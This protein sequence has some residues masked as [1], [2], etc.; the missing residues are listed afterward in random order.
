MPPELRLGLA[1]DQSLRN[2]CLAA[3]WKEDLKS[4]GE[5]GNDAHTCRNL[6]RFFGVLRFIRRQELLGFASGLEWCHQGLELQ[7]KKRRGRRTQPWRSS[8][9][10]SFSI[11]S[12]RCSFFICVT[13]ILIFS[14]KYSG[15]SIVDPNPGS[16]SWGLLFCFL[17]STSLQFWY[18]EVLQCVSIY[19]L[20]ANEA[21][22]LG[23]LMCR[24]SGSC[25]EVATKFHQVSTPH[26]MG[27]IQWK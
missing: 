9:A 5:R 19:A 22:F 2:A 8:S 11:L 21:Q 14:F 1:E 17:A 23:E 20:G 10:F 12:T 18:W 24:C 15:L 16:W 13:P 4:H 6:I 25:L 27:L 3:R 7:R 26:T